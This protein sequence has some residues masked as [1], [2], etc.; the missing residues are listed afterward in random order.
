MDSIRRKDCENMTKELFG[1]TG[2]G[3][4]IYV[5]TLENSN[6]MKARV[7]NFG[8]ILSNLYVPD[9]KG[10]IED[11]VLGFDKLEDYCKN[12]SF[13]GATVGPSAN[14]IGNAAFKIGG[15]EYKLDVN[16][17]PNNLHSHLEEAFHK[18]VW[19]ITDETDTSVIFS[20][21]SLDGDLGF[22]GNRKFSVTYSLSDDNSLKLVY[23]A[24]SD[25]DTLINMTNHTYFNLRCHKTG[26]VDDYILTLNASAYTPVVKG[27]IPT[28]EI[29]SVDGTP[30]DFTKPRRIGDDIDAD[31]EQI[32]LVGGYDHNFIIDDADGTLR[33]VA[34]VEDSASGR[35]LKAFTTLP[36]VQFYT[37]NFIEKQIGKEGVLYGPR[38]GF[39][40]ETQYFP[41][42]INKPN[43]PS[44][45][46]GPNR[47]YDAVTVYQFI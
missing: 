20:L 25:A 31:F 15:E 23:H 26:E 44:P 21:G 8:A 36:G 2:D 7:I 17:G 35:K 1:T 16:D 39:C 19:D 46:F 11:I 41:D 32:K 40:L 29:V 43:F 22:P 9:A 28:G 4:E 5:F 12:V 6:G 14:R 3:K 47:D 10:N 38:A 18:R 33:E 24:E 13:F 30:L 27:A 37:G 34:I 45:V 42:A